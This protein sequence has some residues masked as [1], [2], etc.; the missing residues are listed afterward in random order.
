MGL[1]YLKTRRHSLAED[2][3]APVTVTAY[4]FSLGEKLVAWQ[5]VSEIRAWKCDRLTTAE[6]FIGFTFGD[7]CVAVSEERA[8]FDILESAMIAAFPATSRWRQAVLNPPFESNE[9]VL[10]RRA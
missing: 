2:A 9:T 5:T 6:T 4:G 7:C 10:F 8:G 1:H 3:C